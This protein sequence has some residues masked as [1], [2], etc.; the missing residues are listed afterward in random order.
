MHCHQTENYNN[1]VS[2]KQAEP[3]DRAIPNKS[4]VKSFSFLDR[5]REEFPKKSPVNS[6]FSDCCILE[7]GKS[8][9]ID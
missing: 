1:T 5:D 8:S 3:A 9:P 4:F 2:W 6:I 7:T